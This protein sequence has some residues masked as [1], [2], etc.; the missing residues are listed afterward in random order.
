MLRLD[1]TLEDVIYKVVPELQESE[2]RR[3]RDF[4]KQRNC[5]TKEKDKEAEEI[6]QTNASDS[7]TDPASKRMKLSAADENFHRDD[8]Q[9][10]VCLEC[11][12]ADSAEEQ[13][14]RKLVRKYIR[15]SSRLTIAQIKKFLKVKL[16]LKTAD[17]VEVMCNGE[18]MG[19]DHT[20]EFVYM[21][22]WRIK[23]GSVLMLQYRP[24]IDFS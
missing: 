9:I 7:E 10:G 4:C 24:R 15:C 5:E 14:V 17:Q 2:Q 20:L 23:E 16:D 8:P 6:K 18:I 13:P 1:K 22:R 21:T 3:E 11:L 19:K 12:H